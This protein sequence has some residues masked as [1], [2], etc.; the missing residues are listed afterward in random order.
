VNGVLGYLDPGS[1]SMILQ[2]VVGGVA[3]AAVMGQLYWRRFLSLLRIRK[4][5]DRS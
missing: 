3:A 5:D 2:A 4:K 1:G